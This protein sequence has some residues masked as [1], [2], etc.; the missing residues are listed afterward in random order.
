MRFKIEF[1]DRQFHPWVLYE[2]VEPET[3]LFRRRRSYWR[4]CTA[5]DTKEQAEKWM[6]EKVEGEK[7]HDTSYYDRLGN[8]DF[9]W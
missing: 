5:T 6:K 1:L 7:K 8:A 2:Y 9:C 4:E 3:G